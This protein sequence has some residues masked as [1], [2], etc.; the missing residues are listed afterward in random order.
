MIQSQEKS[1]GS[2]MDGYMVSVKY[3]LDKVTLKG[4]YQLADHDGDDKK[5]AFT[6]GADYKLAKS[7]KLYA[8]YSTFD[9][10]SSND[11]DYLAAG[12]EYKF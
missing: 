9:M 12:I 3:P 6:M 8:F 1:D 11:R 7:T 4:Q 2:E 10:D 5:S